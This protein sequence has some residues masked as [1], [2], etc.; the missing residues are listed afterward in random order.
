MRRR[1]GAPASARRMRVI[2]T[3]HEIGER[4]FDEDQLVLDAAGAVVA[5]S[6]R[7]AL[8]PR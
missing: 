5:Q 7:L 4:M 1:A 6:R 2:A 8:I 3:A